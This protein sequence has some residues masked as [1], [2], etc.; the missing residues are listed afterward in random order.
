M[1]IPINNT[2]SGNVL[3]MAFTDSGNF[4]M[5]EGLKYPEGLKGDSGLI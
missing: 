4:F 1:P 5:L 3:K 2:I